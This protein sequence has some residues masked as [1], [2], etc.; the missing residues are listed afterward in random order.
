[1][2]MIFQMTLRHGMTNAMIE[3]FLKFVNKIIGDDKALPCTKY[4]F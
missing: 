1:M 2:L 3:D 4:M